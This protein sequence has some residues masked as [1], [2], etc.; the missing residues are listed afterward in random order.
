MIRNRLYCILHFIVYKI[1]ANNKIYKPKIYVNYSCKLQRKNVR[2]L[3]FAEFAASKFIFVFTNQNQT[4]SYTIIKS[5]RGTFVQLT[6]RQSINYGN[7]FSDVSLPS[8]SAVSISHIMHSLFL[9]LYLPDAYRPD[10]PSVS[11][12]GRF[13]TLVG[14]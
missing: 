7:R 5:T 6:R 11:L 9:A 12:P 10:D 2:S 3:P 13:S 14:E 1:L 4:G 8:T